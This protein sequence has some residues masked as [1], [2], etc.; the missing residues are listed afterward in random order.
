MI[1][2]PYRV[3]GVWYYP[4]EDK[5]YD[6]VG[7]ASWYGPG[8]H[9]NRT[10]NGERYDKR[11]FTAAHT[12]L[13][14]PVLVRVT[15]LQNGHSTI[16]RV[17]DR[18]PFVPGRII[19]VSEAAANALDFRHDGVVRVRVQ[20]VG[21]ADGPSVATAP[22]LPSAPAGVPMANAAEA[23]GATSFPPA[24]AMAAA[25]PQPST[26]PDV[27]T[28]SMVAASMRRGSPSHNHAR[29]VVEMR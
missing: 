1:G 26:S 5:A 17:N 4:A 15:N 21:R 23:T 29:F 13:P 20:Y 6:H 27:S 16:V 24:G 10:A 3:N 11:R 8:F 7:F 25:A 22:P 28:S 9:G 14:M 12:T 18:G 2:K 19:D